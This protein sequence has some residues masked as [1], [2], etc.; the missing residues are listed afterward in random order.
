MTSYQA[1]IAKLRDPRNVP[2]Y[3]VAYS[4]DCLLWAFEQDDVVHGLAEAHG[5]ERK[6]ISRMVAAEDN[7]VTDGPYS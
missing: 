6:A 1:L 5:S 3:M 2:G 4:L 7:L